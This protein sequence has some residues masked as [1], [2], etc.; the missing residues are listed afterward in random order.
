VA[1]MARGASGPGFSVKPGE[2]QLVLPTQQALD[3]WGLRVRANREQVDRFRQVEDE[4]DFY[5]P[6]ASM[7]QDDPR[8]ESE[9]ALNVLRSLANSSDTWLDIG[10]GGGRYALPLAL[11]AREVIALEPSAGMLAVLHE[12]MARH[13][14]SNIRIVQSRWPTGDE[15]RADVA[16]I[17]HVGYDIEEIGPFLDAVERTAIK[18]CVAVLF[19]RQPTWA[20]DALWPEVHGETRATLPA[21]PEF[22]ALQ[23]ARRRLFELRLVPRVP[24]SYESIEQAVAF[25][26]RQTWVRAGSRKDRQLRSA[27][28]RRL[29]ESGGRYAFSWEP[30]PVGIVTWTS[31]QSPASA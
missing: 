23:L 26:R 20:L 27:V 21:L 12:G 22:L 2:A 7:F 8:R 4:P 13:Q 19:Q 30:S 5:A 10:A 31:H 3:L 16:L 6:I 24:Q 11:V 9:P 15:I 18:L 25:A 17:A 14:I 1:H 28:A 29:I